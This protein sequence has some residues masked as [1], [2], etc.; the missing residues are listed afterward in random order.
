VTLTR[1]TRYALRVTITTQRGLHYEKI[2]SYSVT[3]SLF[4]PPS[5]ASLEKGES[6]PD[7]KL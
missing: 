7:L 2:Y 4:R 6:A 3:V 5:M 1:V